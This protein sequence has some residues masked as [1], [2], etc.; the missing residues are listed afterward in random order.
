MDSRGLP[1]KHR[2]GGGGEEWRRGEKKGKG[3]GKGEGREKGKRM[4]LLIGIYS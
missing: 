4:G 3:K 2:R 1:Q